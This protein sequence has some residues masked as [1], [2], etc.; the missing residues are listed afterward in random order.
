MRN[1]NGTT[2]TGAL[3][4]AVAAATP[5]VAGPNFIEGMDAGGTPGS[6]TRVTGMGP[7]FTISGSLSSLGPGIPD[8]EDMFVIS[9]IDALA[10]SASTE[11]PSTTFDTQLWL[12]RFDDFDPMMNGLG[13]LGNR[14]AGM[15]NDAS[16]LGPISTDGTIAITEGIYY[17]AISGGAGLGVADPGRHPVDAGS[18][19]VFAVADLIGT[20]FDILSPDPA[21]NAIAGWTGEGGT[22]SYII[23]LEGVAFVPVPSAVWIGSLGI[24]AVIVMRRKIL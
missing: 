8:L 21:A 12:F 14:D 13:L 2:W 1:W 16:M 19:P 24:V 22:G 9:I 4:L 11:D 15:G 17:L 6:A 10:F 3:V 5:A 7:L 23:H 20:P 18:V